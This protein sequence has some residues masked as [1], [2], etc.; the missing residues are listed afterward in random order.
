MFTIVFFRDITHF[1]VEW[2]H[3]SY[4]Y[5]NFVCNWVIY[6]L[7]LLDVSVQ[8]LWIML[9]KDVT[10]YMF[11]LDHTR[12]YRLY[13]FSLFIYLFTYLVSLIHS[14][15]LQLTYFI[16]YVNVFSKCVLRQPDQ[17]WDSVSFNNIQR[18]GDYGINTLPLSYL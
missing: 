17:G 16:E 14:V 1:R 4:G 18:L 15:T 11:Y 8:C 5:F 12:R 13:N 6:Y 7:W 9:F 2:P 3:F 10:L